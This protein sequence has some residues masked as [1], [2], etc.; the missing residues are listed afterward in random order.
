MQPTPPKRDVEEDEDVATISSRGS[1]EEPP[2]KSRRS[3]REILEDF[4][5]KETLRELDF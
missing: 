4:L 1:F 5:K 2:R 3:N